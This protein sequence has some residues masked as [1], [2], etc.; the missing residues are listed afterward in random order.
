MKSADDI[1][2]FF[3]KAAI[4]TNPSMDNTVL[5]K[6]LS[7]QEKTKS[8]ATKPNIR[9][10]IM[11]SPITKL[12]AAAVI[13]IAVML[14]IHLWDKSTPSAYAFE[15]TVEAMQGKRSFHIQTYWGSP[16]HRKD[17]YWAEFD[18][19]A[20][21][22][23]SRQEESGGPIAT[24][25]EDNIRTRYYP[26]TGIQLIT[27]VGKTEGELEEFDPEIEVQEVCEQVAKGEATI[28]IQEPSTCDGLITI[29]VTR[30]DGLFRR[31]LLIDPDTDFVTRADRY[32]QTD[33]GEWVYIDG[34]EV[35]EYN[36]PF[37]ANVFSL[38]LSEDTIILDQ[39]SQE[40]GMAQGQMTDEEVA[41]MIVSE[42][43]EAWTAGNYV[44][45][46]KLLGGAPTELLTERYDHLRPVSIISVSQPQ[47]IEYRKTWFEVPC[48]YEVE[49]DGQINTI[50]P[51]LHVLAVDG[52]PGRLYVS[53]E[54]NP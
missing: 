11:R 20:E 37:N 26:R 39:V 33:D 13:I 35:L 45:A 42:V 43:L 4:D 9:R 46:G 21:L 18:E 16:T 36:Q 30:T 29:T 7:V 54:P 28:E 24:V 31:I 3:N 19:N 44:K 23:R 5:N 51:K 52:Q 14:S 41:T 50:E 15:Q 8:A 34:I 38:N 10:T 32:R 25:W 12:A 1:K 40:V 17:E 6:V 2:K 22:L 49:R 47:P 27:R 53:I 48:V